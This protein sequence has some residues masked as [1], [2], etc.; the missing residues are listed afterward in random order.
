MTTS[1]ETKGILENQGE[2]GQIQANDPDIMLVKRWVESNKRPP[3]LEICGKG[4]FVRSLWSQFD[5]LEINESLLCRRLKPTELNKG[6]YQI[7]VPYSERRR[8]LEYCH[9]Q[10]FSA[11]LGIHKTLAKVRQRYYWPGLQSDVRSYVTGCG[12]CNKRKR[13]QKTKRAPMQ[14]YETSC[15]MDRIATDILGE[16]PE[17]ESG[18]K[19][20]LVVSDYFTKWTESFPMPNM[21]A[22]TVAKIIVEE[23]IVRFGVPSY[24]HSDQGRQYESRL[25]QEVCDILHIKKTRTTP[26]HPQSDGMV[27]RFNHTLVTMLSAYVSE[28]QR[29]W[30]MHLPYVMM[31]YRSAEHET[32][33][34]TPNFLMLGREVATPL[35]IMYEMPNSV[36]QIPANM[37]A[38]EMKEK[39][40][41]AHNLVRA[42]SQ[43][44]MRRQKT[45]HDIKLSWQNF[46]K[47]DE[48][49]VYFPLRKTGCTAKLPACGEVLIR[50]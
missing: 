15:P 6:T 25:F 10:K 3:F 49:Y 45:Y 36:K 23:F 34:Q 19:Y 31:A 48:V 41:N 38:W 20:I 40:E 9:D 28:H 16:L 29:D 37:W 39:M 4:F 22:S 18:N 27:E 8:I 2:I 32:T 11:H 47:G 17:T 7:I 44:E 33:G 13:P 43:A 42:N 1:T 5:S 30:D 24:V 12:Q 46:E 35:D 50:S 14:L 21:E 26:Y